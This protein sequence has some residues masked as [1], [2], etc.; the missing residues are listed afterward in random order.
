MRKNAFRIICLGDSLTL[1]IPFGELDRWPTQLALALEKKWPGKFSVYNRGSNGATAR[2]ALARLDGEIGWLLPALV[3]VAFGVNEAGMPSWRRTASVGVDQFR[4]DLREIHR[5]V[6]GKG[7]QTAFIAEHEPAPDNRPDGQKTYVPGNGRTYR[8]NYL[9]Y[10]QAVLEVARELKAPL[11]DIPAQMKAHQVKTES[12]VVEDGLHLTLD[13][14]AFYANAV[15][16]GIHPLLS[17]L[18]PSSKNA[19]AALV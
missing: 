3:L 2:D 8:E 4:S 14:N 11:I 9:P 17:S 12:L 6:A 7:G 5:Y 18:P 16:D 15:F 19:A 1:G 10:H 13:G